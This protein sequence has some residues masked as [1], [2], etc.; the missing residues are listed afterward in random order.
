MLPD[1]IA[2]EALAAGTLVRILP[3][4]ALPPASL[5]LLTPPSRLRPARV[6]ALSDY[7]ASALK[8]SCAAR[9][10]PESLA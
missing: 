9:D 6:Q 3:G 4:W 7:L 8:T 5:H 2:A 10:S 1:F